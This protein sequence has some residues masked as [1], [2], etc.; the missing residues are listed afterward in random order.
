MCGCQ[1]LLSVPRWTVKFFDLCTNS[2]FMCIHLY[3]S[4]GR[5]MQIINNLLRNAN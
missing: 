2:L 1:V 3:G 4:N 5:F